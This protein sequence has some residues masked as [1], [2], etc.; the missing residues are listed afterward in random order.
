L[1]PQG[2]R[3]GKLHGFDKRPRLGG[4]KVKKREQKR[5]VRIGGTIQK[6]LG[7]FDKGESQGHGK[8]PRKALKGR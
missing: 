6:I 5:E 2:T 3:W 4:G 1:E 7:Y 8:D